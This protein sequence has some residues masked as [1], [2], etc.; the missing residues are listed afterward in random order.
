MYK[1]KYMCYELIIEAVCK[2]CPVE[3]AC[4][5]DFC[6]GIL[7]YLLDDIFSFNSTFLLKHTFHNDCTC[8]ICKSVPRQHSLPYW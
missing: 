2:E 6:T 5:I 8:L 3:S 7:L 4:G 1:L